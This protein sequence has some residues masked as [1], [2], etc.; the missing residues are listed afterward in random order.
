MRLPVKFYIPILAL[1]TLVGLV[2]VG[3]HWR[4]A[5]DKSKTVEFIAAVVGGITAIYTLLL[6]IQQRRT[7]AAAA[8]MQRWNNPD[9]L[10]YRKLV[11]KSIDAKSVQSLD[12]LGIGIVLS[13][14]EEVAIAILHNESDESLMKEFFFSPCLRFFEAAKPDIDRRRIQYTQP[15]AFKEYERLYLRWCPNT[16]GTP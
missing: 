12:E 2:A 1:L 16:T 15:T 6:S 7:A 4:L 3:F 5:A 14:W 13:F 10:E 8:F 11:R 9:F